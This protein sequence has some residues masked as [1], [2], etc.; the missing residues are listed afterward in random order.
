MVSAAERNVPNTW[1]FQAMLGLV[2]LGGG[3]VTL[4]RLFP[5]RVQRFN[6]FTPAAM[7]SPEFPV[8]RVLSALSLI[9]VATAG[10]PA[11][12]IAPPPRLITDR[13]ALFRK[14]Q[15]FN[16]TIEIGKVEADALR[17]E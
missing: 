12:N 3:S 7:R 13:D 15:V 2:K 11:A 17:R 9:A 4:S 14:P 5:F 8:K 10:L 1:K 16:L 6:L